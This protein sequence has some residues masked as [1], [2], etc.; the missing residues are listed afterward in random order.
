MI[1]YKITFLIISII[2]I[3]III[4]QYKYITTSPFSVLHLLEMVYKII[5]ICNQ[6]LVFIVFTMN[7]WY[8]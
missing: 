8:N 2:N 6:C 1:T 3:I 7:F 4:W 5:F